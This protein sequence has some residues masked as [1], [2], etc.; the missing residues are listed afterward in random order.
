L[1]SLNKPR[2][3]KLA[4]KIDFEKTVA[5]SAKNLRSV[6][7]RCTPAPEVRADEPEGAD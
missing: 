7:E 5:E 6:V 1:E 3:A 2:P 4:K